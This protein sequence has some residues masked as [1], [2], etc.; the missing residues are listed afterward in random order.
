[1]CI[2]E[3]N[4]KTPTGRSNYLAFWEKKN[5]PDSKKTNKI[6]SEGMGERKSQTIRATSLLAAQPNLD[7]GHFRVY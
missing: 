7:R 2:K 1:M 6:A 3:A 4:P 5:Y